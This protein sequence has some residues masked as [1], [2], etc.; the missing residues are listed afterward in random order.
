MDLEEKYTVEEHA[1]QLKHMLWG[2]F[3]RKYFPASPSTWRQ[4]FGKMCNYLRICSLPFVTQFFS[5]II[6]DGHIL[7]WR[8]FVVGFLVNDCV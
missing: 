6:A 8:G 7:D 2:R 4:K 3:S 1:F 5:L